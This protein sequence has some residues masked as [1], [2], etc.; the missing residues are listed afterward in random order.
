MKARNEAA[1]QGHRGHRNHS[2]P[3]ETRQGGARQHGQSQKRGQRADRRLKIDQYFYSGQKE[4]S[5]CTYR[6]RYPVA[7]GETLEAPL[8]CP[9]PKEKVTSSNMMF[10][11]NNGKVQPK[12]VKSFA[13]ASAKP[14]T[15]TAKKK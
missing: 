5:A 2:G 13:D 14:A 11:H 4:V 9:M 15:T 7:A 10:T 3:A 1:R 12:Q 8:S 6:V